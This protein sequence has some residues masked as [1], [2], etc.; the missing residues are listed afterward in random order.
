MKSISN[1]PGKQSKEM[2]VELRLFQKKNF[3]AIRILFL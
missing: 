2:C 1:K 3:Y